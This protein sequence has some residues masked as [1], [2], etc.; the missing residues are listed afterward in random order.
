[1]LLIKWLLIPLHEL[2]ACGICPCESCGKITTNVR[3]GWGRKRGDFCVVDAK[4]GMFFALFYIKS[5]FFL[6]KIT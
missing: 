3:E 5:P 6:P 4:K 1:M 2:F